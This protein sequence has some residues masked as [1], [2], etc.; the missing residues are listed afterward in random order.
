M[1]E[2]DKERSIRLLILA[3]HDFAREYPEDREENID[4]VCRLANKIG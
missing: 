4:F 3:I 1:S 2:K